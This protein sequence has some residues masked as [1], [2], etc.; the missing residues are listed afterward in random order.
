LT[1]RQVGQPQARTAVGTP[2]R[3]QAALIGQEL[4]RADMLPRIA[5]S[6]VALMVAV[7]RMPAA[8]VECWARGHRHATSGRQPGAETGAAS[9]AR[10]AEIM[11][12]SARFVTARPSANRRSSQR[13]RG[14]R[15]PARPS[16][17]GPCKGTNKGTA[18]MKQPDS[19]SKSSL[20][21]TWYRIPDSRKGS[22]GLRLNTI[23]PVAF[24]R[25][26]LIPARYRVRTR[27]RS[28]AA[29]YSLGLG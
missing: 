13:C 15:A 18:C 3:R 1:A 26:R 24:R 16:A 17:L 20:D 7:D 9:C 12:L 11:F 8:A 27:V 19:R 22:G 5:V 6:S 28:E 14:S 29:R 10:T 2:P 4:D 21:E 25:V 23:L